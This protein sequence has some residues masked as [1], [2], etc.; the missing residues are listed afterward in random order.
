MRLNFHSTCGEIFFQQKQK[1][2]SILN[3][4]C[5]KQNTM[6]RVDESFFEKVF[7]SCFFQ[8]QIATLSCCNINLN[9]H[10]HWGENNVFCLTLPQNHDKDV[11]STIL[12][13]SSPKRFF[14][15]LILWS[16]CFFIERKKHFFGGNKILSKFLFLG[17]FAPLFE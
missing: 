9:F 5:S 3:F 12:N 11:Q 4:F 17:S 1:I 10:S 8:T 7:Q 2:L 13:A 14:E 15:P 16:C 6:E